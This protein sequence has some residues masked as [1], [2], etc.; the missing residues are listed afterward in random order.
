MK[1]EPSKGVDCYKGH[2]HRGCM[3]GVIRFGV[4]IF[5]CHEHFDELMQYPVEDPNWNQRRDN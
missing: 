3:T 1:D 2:E 5:T 4:I